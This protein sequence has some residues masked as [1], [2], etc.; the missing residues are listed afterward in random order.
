MPVRRGP[1]YEMLRAQP[2]AGRL[3]TSDAR[4]VLLIQR[5]AATGEGRGVVSSDCSAL[6]S[7]HWRLAGLQEDHVAV[8]SR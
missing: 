6:Q 2:L 7:I 4:A 1:D 8:V 3:G 5:L